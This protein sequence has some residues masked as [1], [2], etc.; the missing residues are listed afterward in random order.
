MLIGMT[1]CVVGILFFFRIT[2]LK[3]AVIF[4]NETIMSMPLTNSKEYAHDSFITDKNK[5]Y[6]DETI[7]SIPPHKPR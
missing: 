2:G 7:M 1:G 3:N 6:T 5:L 4:S